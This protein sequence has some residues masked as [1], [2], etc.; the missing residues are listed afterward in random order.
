MTHFWKKPYHNVLLANLSLSFL[1]LLFAK[2][3]SGLVFVGPLAGLSPRF[4]SGKKIEKSVCTK[5]DALQNPKSLVN[6]D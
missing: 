4:I 2:N 5:F 1:S 6:L 3:P